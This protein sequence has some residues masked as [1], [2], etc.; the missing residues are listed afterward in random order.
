MIEAN[1]SE[2]KGPIRVDTVP[3]GTMLAE[4]E[5][6]LRK[7]EQRYEMSSEKMATL[8]EADAIRP[9][10]EVIKWYSTFQGAKLLRGTTR[11]TGTLGTTI[12]LSTKAV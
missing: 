2:T 12:G 4:A 11:T 6:D 9:T 3:P 5:S 7:Y 8:L 10:A 1:D